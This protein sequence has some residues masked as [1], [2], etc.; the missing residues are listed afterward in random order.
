[1][2]DGI[3][4][5]QSG[6]GPVAPVAT[7]P[8]QDDAVQA[9]VPSLGSVI[10][11][12]YRVEELIARGGMGA[13]YSA[14]HLVSG[15]KVALKWMLPALGQ[16]PG[17]KDRF[18][19]EACATARIEHPNVID[20]YDVGNDRGSVYLV[21]EL[22]RGETLAEFL[23][24]T[25][26][27][28]AAEAI[29][30]LMPALRGVAAA[31]SHH[32]IHR[33][34]KPDN[35]FLC[36][37]SEG[38]P[39][40]PRVLDFGISKIGSGDDPRLSLTRSGAVMGTPYY[41]SPE[42]VRGAKEVDERGDIYAFGVILY[43]ML[44]GQRPFEAETYNQLIL[45]IATEDPAPMLELNP[46]VDRRLAAVIERAMARDPN[47][48]FSSIEELALALEPFSNGMLF[49][50]STGR[51]PIVT[52]GEHG[53]LNA[54]TP[55][56]T[57]YAPPR[58]PKRSRA[59]MVLGIALGGIGAGLGF[60]ALAYQRSHPE[61]PSPA[62]LAVP[63]TQPKAAAAAAAETDLSA[64]TRAPVELVLPSAPAEPVVAEH[65]V[66]DSVAKPAPDRKVRMKARADA[67]SSPAVPAAGATKSSGKLPDDWDERLSIPTRRAASSTMP[68]G[69]IDARDLR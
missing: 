66:D 62:I 54:S 43:E 4:P 2:S 41:M 45:K 61:D 65:R 1:M 21:M 44:T 68:A 8:L 10:A 48:R 27:V 20:I 30:L 69:P 67:K 49:R 60:W 7:L 55:Y 16:V 35:I 56:V 37:S 5:S 14:T 51:P 6:S 58:L 13:V 50:A 63:S 28:S 47:H 15:K 38:E 46:F 40:E 57:S 34:L 25:P 39:R 9:A 42:Q 24:R 32:V 53:T 12:K 64:S 18:Q 19:R 22:L 59:Y 33:D 3:P 31:H 26:Q 11:D 52:S 17:A 36:R 23:Q 29:G